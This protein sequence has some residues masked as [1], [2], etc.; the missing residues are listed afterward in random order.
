MSVFEDL[1]RIAKESKESFIL[2]AVECYNEA[3]TMANE[4]QNPNQM[5]NS[6]LQIRF[7][8]YWPFIAQAIRSPQDI[9][10]LMAMVHTSL[11]QH[12]KQTSGGASVLDNTK[13][14]LFTQK[15]GF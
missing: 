11:Q 15:A 5:A 2:P 12:Q 7:N 6:N 9:R 8:K 4:P 13:G 14:Q 10:Q 3:V 1:Q